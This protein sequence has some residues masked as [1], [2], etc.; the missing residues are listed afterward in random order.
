MKKQIVIGIF[1]AVLCALRISGAA[2]KADEV[3]GGWIADID[4]QRHVYLLNV[5]GTVISG[6]YCWDCS[7]PENLAFVLDGKLE[8]DGFSFVLLHDAG[9]GAPYREN[10]KGRVVDGRLVL[11]NQRQNSAAA[12]RQI[13]MMREPRRP[14]SGIILPGAIAPLPAGADPPPAAVPAPTTAGGQGDRGGAVPPGGGRGPNAAAPVPVPGALPAGARGRGGYV[15]PGPN[16]RLTA[17]K[18]A[19]L[20][21]W[22]T[23]PGKQYFIFRQVGDEIRGVVCGPCDNPFTFGVLADGKVSGDVFRFNIVHEDWGIGIQNGAFN[24]QAT[25]TISMN[26]MR[27]ATRQDNQPPNTP[28][29]D[30]TLLGPIRP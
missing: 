19:G 5:R 23:G 25:A 14:A 20:W 2:L 13:T 30:M 3:R 29:L 11:T 16:E 24:N 8:E 22:G 1:A 7:N 6:I 21:L 10:V 4:G 17:A 18:V 15:P 28:T 26:E 9:P 12:P 27:I